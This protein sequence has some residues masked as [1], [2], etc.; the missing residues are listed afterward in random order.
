MK[1]L[2]LMLFFILCNGVQAA[3][4]LTSLQKITIGPDD[5]H[6]GVFSLPQNRLIF[7]KDVN[8]A[9][10]L[11]YQDLA[12][13]ESKPLM[14]VAKDSKDPTLSLSGSKLAYSDFSTDAFGDICIYQEGCIA[15]SGV[16]DYSPLFVGDETLYFL[17]EK[18]DRSS[19]QLLKYHLKQQ[20]TEEVLQGK[21]DFFT[22][23]AD[24]ADLIYIQGG[25]L[26]HLVD[27]KSNAHY[28]ITV[29]LPGMLG[30]PA[31]SKDGQ[32]LYWAQFF[33]DSNHDQIIDG[34]DNGVI[35]RYPI[36]QLKT[37]A[38]ST[39]FPEQI[40]SSENNCSYPHPASDNNLYLTCAF[41]GSLDIYRLPL[42]GVVPLAWS[43]EQYTEAYKI[44]RSYSERLLLL[45]N[46]TYRKEHGE[47][48]LAM[49]KRFYHL[50]LLSE[51]Y[52]V[53]LYY[54]ERLRQQDKM[55]ARLMPYL[56]MAIL[57]ETLPLQEV[58]I[59]Y[60]EAIN[61]IAF[62]A[63]FELLQAYKAYFLK[64][65]ARSQ[66]I[67]KNLKLSGLKSS[68]LFHLYI[69]LATKVLKR[70]EQP[71]FYQR[72]LL[73]A[74]HNS[75]EQSYY[76]YHLFEL[77]DELQWSA[78]QK[79]KFY[80]ELMQKI[81]K[82]QAKESLKLFISAEMLIDELAVAADGAQPV[83]RK[84]DKLITENRTQYFL[85]R[86]IFIRA[87]I[88]LTEMGK[89]QF[90]H[91]LST[92]WVRFTGREDMEFL[93]A[94]KQYNYYIQNKSYKHLNSKDGNNN[95]ALNNFYGSLTLTDDIESHFGF[96][97]LT[98]KER[99]LEEGERELES[100]YQNLHL[101][102]MI[103][104]N[105]TYVKVLRKLLRAPAKASYEHAISE[106]SSMG[107]KEHSPLRFL[108]LGYAHYKLQQ[109]ESAH[110]NFVL[111]S[112][113]A[114][115]NFRIRAAALANLALVHLRSKNY[116]LSAHYFRERLNYPFPEKSTISEEEAF[117]WF[118]AKTLFLSGDFKEAYLQITKI[119]NSA[120]PVRERQA[121]YALYANDY[122]NAIRLY[123][124]LLK[125][126]SIGGG[127]KSVN[128]SKLSLALAFA[129]YKSQEFQQA[130]LPL[131]D[132]L[133]FAKDDNIRQ[134][135]VAHG[136]LSEIYLR[137]KNY[138]ESALHRGARLALLEELFGGKKQMQLDLS[139]LSETLIKEWSKLAYI[140]HLSN[141]SGQAIAS[142]KRSFYW[143]ENLTKDRLQILTSYSIYQGVKNYLTLCK[144]YKLTPPATQR[145]LFSQI[146]LAYE[147]EI[148]KLF[149]GQRPLLLQ[150]SQKLKALIEQLPH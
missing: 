107:E 97:D 28:L 91:Y 43:E 128:Y 9:V 129:L 70:A 6:Q 135:L 119:K 102:K 86:A 45:Y 73:Y 46:L 125:S 53:V 99:G 148:P 56:Q 41:E 68:L 150:Q 114:L 59:E 112:D 72:L 33:T 137:A 67:L 7:A 104:D 23:T 38:K 146:L 83:Y 90:A 106:L 75:E 124:E 134:S 80:R 61:K 29:N 93:L 71:L 111:A 65:Y 147:T 32:Y 113:L 54:G 13:G 64:E 94:K 131:K 123:R 138:P 47:L 143:L 82:D 105:I 98:L 122:A 2:G 30:F 145:E 44:S 96:V 25:N 27:M 20:T 37:K 8:M 77:L 34:Y 60:R 126:G 57:H 87:I 140:Y 92:N 55:V 81:E 16:R 50:H 63:D 74:P 139:Y 26:I 40:T 120:T 79:H 88:K 58:T 118:Y 48:S 52:S 89:I 17:S 4:S 84:L 78:S 110:R 132:V 127:S 117:Y 3:V 85:K 109:Y 116:S 144:L 11:Y 35:F 142:G 141:D 115:D 130:I 66:E 103:G 1:R 18:S 24:G 10:N 5:S 39:I 21:I 149:P 14:G 42:E 15:R 133:N 95:Y 121:F 69:E 136:L 51:E 12:N 19:K 101:R 108:L 100:Q 76:A 22:I 31:T 62:A 49:M 36:S